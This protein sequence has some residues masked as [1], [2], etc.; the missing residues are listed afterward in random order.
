M[1]GRDDTTIT[2]SSGNVFADLGLPDAEDEL[3]RAALAREIG[4]VI[5][6]RGLTQMAAAVAMGV[7]QPKVSAT[8]MGRLGGFSLERLAYFLTLLGKDVEIVVREKPAS[9]AAGRLSVVSV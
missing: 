4:T 3:T 8:L 5:R 2:P 6:T 7:D 9:Q 1:S